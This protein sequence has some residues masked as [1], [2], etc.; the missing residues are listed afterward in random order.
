[1]DE[2][3][4]AGRGCRGEGGGLGAK[5][6]DGKEPGGEGR[7]GREVADDRARMPLGKGCRDW[8]VYLSRFGGKGEGWVV[9]GVSGG[10]WRRDE[11]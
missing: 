9:D 2:R 4:G 7:R 6:R 5:G 10:E 1:M 11:G 8:Y 3:I